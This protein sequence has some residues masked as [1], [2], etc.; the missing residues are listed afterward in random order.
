MALYE[1]H[2]PNGNYQY[3]N[4]LLAK[5]AQLAPYDAAIKHSSAEFKLRSVDEGQSR[6]ERSKSLKDAGAILRTLVANDNESARAHHTLAKAGIRT[7]RE[8][9]AARHLQRGM[10]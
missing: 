6:L 2:R 8:T 5:A 4:R 7:L 10:S 1:M 3:A 9:L